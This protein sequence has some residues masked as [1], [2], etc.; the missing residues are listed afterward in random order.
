MAKP[1]TQELMPGAQPSANPAAREEFEQRCRRPA[2]SPDLTQKKLGL[3]SKNDGL[4]M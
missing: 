3:T 4:T 1:A 2:Q